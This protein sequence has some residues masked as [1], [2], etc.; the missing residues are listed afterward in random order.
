[1]A[2]KTKA[3]HRGR[4][5]W[6]SRELIVA[7]ILLTRPHT[8]PLTLRGAVIRQDADPTKELPLADVEI[9]ALSNGVGD[10]RRQ[11]GCLRRFHRHL[12]NAALDRPAGHAAIPPCRLP[13]AGPERVRGRQAI[14]GPHGAAVPHDANAAN[15]P[16]HRGVECAGPLF[17]QDHQHGQRRQRGKNLRSR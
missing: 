1:M 7:A 12:A 9:A 2:G 13:A 16:D 10:R 8:R 17:H 14:R 6:S 5:P 3:D 11:V 4:R 15:R